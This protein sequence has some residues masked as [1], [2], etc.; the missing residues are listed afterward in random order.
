MNNYERIDKMAAALTPYEKIVITQ[1]L[2]TEGWI[3]VDPKTSAEEIIDNIAKLQK[4]LFY[5]SL[6]R[7][8]DYY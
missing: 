1:K 3:I 2:K 5:K 7:E 8:D 4:M 6:E